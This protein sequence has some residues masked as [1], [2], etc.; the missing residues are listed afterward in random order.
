MKFGDYIKKEREKHSWTQ[1]EAA[2]KADIEQ[3]YLSKLETGK[4]Y[5]SEDMYERLVGAYGIDTAHMCSVV[6]SA[7]LDKLREIADVRGA[8]LSREKTEVSYL[9]S[10]LGAGLVMLMIGTGLVAFEY[11]QGYKIEFSYRY[12]SPGI[13]KT[14]EPVQI[15]KYLAAQEEYAWRKRNNTLEKNPDAKITPPDPNES[16]SDRVSFHVL[17]YKDNIGPS[18]MKDVAGG[19]RRYELVDE[20]RHEFLLRTNLVMALGIALIMGA[21]GCG[22]I[23]RRWR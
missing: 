5:P 23:S 11:N 8:I 2:A 12:Q 16:Y 7:E 10:W 9:R 6:Y 15:F 20:V 21:F 22:F 13:I 3:S 17:N 18:F 1:P 14:G 19:Q 4:S